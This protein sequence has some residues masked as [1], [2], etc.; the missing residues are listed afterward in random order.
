MA[1]YLLQ[2]AAYRAIL[3]PDTI[4]F[5]CLGNILRKWVTREFSQIAF[6]FSQHA[7]HPEG[8]IEARYK[9]GCCIIYSLD[10]QSFPLINIHSEHPNFVFV[11]SLY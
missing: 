2:S 9:R 8:V 3:M 4:V 6:L 1:G 7:F 10:D 11:S 5:I